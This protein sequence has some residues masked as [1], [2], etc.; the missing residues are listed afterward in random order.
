MILHADLHVLRHLVEG[1]G[2]LPQPR[3]P[4][5]VVL[6]VIKAELCHQLRIGGIDAAHLRHRHLPFLELGAFNVVGQI[7]Q[8]HVVAHLF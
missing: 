3:D 7:G 6:H 5:V 2:N 1:G 4:V 8:Q